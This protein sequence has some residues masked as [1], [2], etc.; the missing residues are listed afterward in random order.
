MSA[1]LAGTIAG[2]GVAN[3]VTFN[4]TNPDTLA[5]LEI[6]NGA[7]P[8]V[9]LQ[10]VW[11]AL[12]VA[13]AQWSPIDA[14][15]VSGSGTVQGTA[16]VPYS[17]ATGPNLLWRFDVSLCQAIRV[18]AAA[19][20]SGIVAINWSAGSFFANPPGAGAPGGLTLQQ[21]LLW[22]MME[23]TRVTAAGLGKE[24]TPNPVLPGGLSPAIWLNF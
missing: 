14:F 7:T 23:L 17:V 15:A 24:A 22:Q 11:E 2:L 5:L 8:Y 4:L 13:S 12:P 20:T 21:A 10:L 3:A 19:L 16:A 18:W 6:S 9:G 1:P